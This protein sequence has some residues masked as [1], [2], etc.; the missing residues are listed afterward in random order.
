MASLLKSRKF[1]LMIL[2]LVVSLAS[3]F[4]GKYAGP[5][6]SKDILYVIG[7]MQP[8]FVSIIIAIAIEDAAEKG[9]PGIYASGP[10]E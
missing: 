8:V 2:D 5:E 4:V 10:A 7:L 3:Y 1:W 6:V 9:N